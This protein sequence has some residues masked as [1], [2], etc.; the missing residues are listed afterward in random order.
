MVVLIIIIV[1]IVIGM[2][3]V[4]V[5]AVNKDEKDYK[6]IPKIH[7]TPSLPDFATIDPVTGQMRM[8]LTYDPSDTDIGEYLFFDT[9][10]T[11][12]PKI[13]DAKPEEL[14]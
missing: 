12:L 6:E 4:F 11:G 9:E 2:I 14:D 10:T 3:I 7:K 5:K 1:V 8:D 13:R